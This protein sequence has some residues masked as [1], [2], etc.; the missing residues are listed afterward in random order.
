MWELKPKIT[1]EHL[2]IRREKLDLFQKSIV[3]SIIIR[4]KRKIKEKTKRY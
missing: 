4:L 3:S 1:E 2:N